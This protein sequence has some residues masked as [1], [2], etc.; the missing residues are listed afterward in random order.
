MTVS[1]LK[2]CDWHSIFAEAAKDHLQAQLGLMHMS[3][4]RVASL[5]LLHLQSSMVMAPFTLGKVHRHDAVISC[6]LSTLCCCTFYFLLSLSRHVMTGMRFILMYD[7]S[8]LVCRATWGLFHWR[9]SA[10]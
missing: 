3:D 2:D 10:L 4:C 8:M 9:W 1:N 7:K 6:L 5:V